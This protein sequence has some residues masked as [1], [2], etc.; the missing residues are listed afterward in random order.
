MPIVFG[1]RFGDKALPPQFFWQQLSTVK[2]LF[3]GGKGVP[4]Q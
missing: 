3:F 1:Y 2:N 4:A